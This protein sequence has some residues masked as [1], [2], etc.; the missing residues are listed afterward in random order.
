MLTTV[1][2]IGEPANEGARGPSEYVKLKL[3]K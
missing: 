3:V 2:G 1:S